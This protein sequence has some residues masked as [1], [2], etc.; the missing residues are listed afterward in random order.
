MDAALVRA[1]MGNFERQAALG[2]LYHHETCVLAFFLFLTI[3]GPLRSIGV[4]HTS[5]LL[6]ASAAVWCVRYLD[7][8]RPWVRIAREWGS[9]AIILPAYWS[10]GFFASPLA[11][12]WQETWV[13]WDRMLL[14]TLRLQNGIEALRPA[15]PAILETL[16]LLLLY[17]IP[18][19]SLGILYACGERDKTK[20][21]LEVLFL[22]TLTAYALLPL[23]PVESPRVAFAG[24]D[25][26]LFHQFPRTMNVWMLNRLDIATSVFPS[27]HVA[28]AFS[29]AFGLFRA[30]PR[31]RRIWGGA[32]V[33]AFPV[34][35]ATIYGRY[36]YTFDGVASFAIA[37][38][39]YWLAG[40]MWSDAP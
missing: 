6:A 27:G 30:V 4:L 28:V 21:F 38:G 26:P 37:A 33:A 22:G 11:T 2:R 12:Q 35:L 36:H 16:Y 9:L 23:F 34:F 3:L 1:V 40:R 39:T 13:R 20:R 15:V 18:P 31:R 7:T 24:E 10:V 14:H 25:S 29:T 19:L 32:L 5:F 8:Q 17:A